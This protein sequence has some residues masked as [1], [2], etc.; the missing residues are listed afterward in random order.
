MCIDAKETDKRLES[1]LRF[2]IDNDL[3]VST[4]Q[5][6]LGK[7]YSRV[8][9]EDTDIGLAYAVRHLAPAAAAKD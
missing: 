2:A 1:V 9:P 5:L 3:R 6:F 8:C 7:S 4:P